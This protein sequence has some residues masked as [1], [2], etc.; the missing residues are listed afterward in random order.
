L[1]IICSYF[2]RASILQSVTPWA[3]IRAP[4][5]EKPG[6]FIKNGL[7]SNFGFSDFYGLGSRM[8]P[9][10]VHGK[11]VEGGRLIVPAAFRKEMGLAKGDAVIMEMHGDE[12]RVR[13]A[14]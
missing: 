2:D 14:K 5:I 4:N 6:N 8:S 9:P 1:F 12:L 7:L 13:P 11:L 10:V 3:S